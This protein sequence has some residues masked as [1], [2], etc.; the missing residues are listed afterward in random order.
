MGSN[1]LCVHGHFYQPPREDPL[2]GLIPD[3]EGAQPYKN[4]NE[5]IHSECY[6]SNAALGNFEKISFNIGPTLTRRRMIPLSP[7]KEE[8]MNA[9]AWA[10]E[11]RKHTIMSFFL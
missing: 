4:W 6:Q 7:R 10:M 2:S 9:M 3:E 8:F 5:R 1:A 11:W